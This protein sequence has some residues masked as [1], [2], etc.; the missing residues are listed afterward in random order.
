MI[1]HLNLQKSLNSLMLFYSVN[2]SDVIFILIQL[3]NS[4]EAPCELNISGFGVVSPDTSDNLQ[5]FEDVSSA[6]GALM[7]LLSSESKQ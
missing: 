3:L 5:V 1:L 2:H 4:E 7:F 6:L